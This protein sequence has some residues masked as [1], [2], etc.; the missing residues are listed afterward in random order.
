MIKKK[1]KFALDVKTSKF[2]NVET[3]IVFKN[4]L[5]KN[6]SITKNKKFEQIDDKVI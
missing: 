2:D 3:R 4:R 1:Y 5:I 6:N